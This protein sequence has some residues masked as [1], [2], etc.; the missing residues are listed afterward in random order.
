M[1]VVTLYFILLKATISA[2]SGLSALPII[3]DELVINHRVMTDGR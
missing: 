1:N 3:R 2:F